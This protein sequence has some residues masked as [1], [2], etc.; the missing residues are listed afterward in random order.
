MCAGGVPPH[1]G[2]PSVRRRA[3]RA[4]SQFYR[5]PITNGRRATFSAWAMSIVFVAIAAISFTVDQTVMV[6][7]A[8]GGDLGQLSNPAQ[9]IRSWIDTAAGLSDRAE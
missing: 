8:A 5:R 4:D 7:L 1:S 3:M 6:S 9:L 2:E